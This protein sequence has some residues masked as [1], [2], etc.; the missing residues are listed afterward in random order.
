MNPP[1]A[2][3]WKSMGKFSYARWSS[4]ILYFVIFA[5]LIC[6]SFF[7]YRNAFTAAKSAQMDPEQAMIKQIYKNLFSQH[8]YGK[9]PK[10]EATEIVTLTYKEAVDYYNSYYHPS[11]GQAFCW[12]K[13]EFV[14]ACLT[15]LEPVLNEYEYNAGIRESSKVEW[16][17]MTNLAT[18]IKEI[19]YPSWQDQMDYRSVVAWVLND[20]PMDLRTEV[21]WLL[22]FELL[23]GST[24]APVPKA[25][26]DL[27]LGDDV[28]TYFDTSLQQWVMALG[29]SGITSE[30]K[31]EIAR[32][33][34]DGKLRN[35]INNGFSKRALEAAMNKIEFRVS[36]VGLF[37]NV[38]SFLLIPSLERTH[39]M[40]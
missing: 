26:A 7:G 14:D 1:V 15:E 37:F 18:E 33:A 21:S 5:W 11:N 40:D 3:D 36:V 8:S 34:I 17:E 6:L 4:E 32:N 35:I 38:F 20:S 22:I 39:A 12:G 9:D 13:Q 24:S 23:A 2:T 30:D 25:I 10:G 31:V 29:V 28:V 19:G 16:Q 27:N